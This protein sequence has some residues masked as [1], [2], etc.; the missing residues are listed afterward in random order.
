MENIWTLDWILHI[1]E[2]ENEYILHMCIIIHM[3]AIIQFCFDPFQISSILLWEEPEIGTLPR[4]THCIVVV[5]IVR[6]M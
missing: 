5:S 4:V 3:R 1:Q 6:L 2:R